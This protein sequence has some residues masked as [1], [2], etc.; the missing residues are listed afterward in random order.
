MSKFDNGVMYYT[1][2]IVR[3]PVNFPE[4]ERKCK[5]CPFCR[6]DNDIRYRCFI[7]NR[8]LFSTETLHD[9]CPIDF[10]TQEDTNEEI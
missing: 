8:I 3:F 9:D 2:G 5:W 10:E 1:Q 6:K 4:D 7:T